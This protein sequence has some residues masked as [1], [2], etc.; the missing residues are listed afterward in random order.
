MLAVKLDFFMITSPFDRFLL[1]GNKK[2][3]YRMA[4]SFPPSGIAAGKEKTG[5][6]RARDFSELHGAPPLRQTISKGG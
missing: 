3:G 1:R 2:T 6:K 5:D 4:H